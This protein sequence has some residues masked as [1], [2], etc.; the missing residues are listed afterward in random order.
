MNWSANFQQDH[1]MSEFHALQP[2]FYHND[3]DLLHFCNSGSCLSEEPFDK[4]RLETSTT[5][6]SPEHEIPGDISEIPDDVT[7]SFLNTSSRLIDAMLTNFVPNE[8]VNDAIHSNDP[9]PKLKVTSE[10]SYDQATFENFQLIKDCMWSGLGRKP[11]SQVPRLNISSS[12]DSSTFSPGSGCINPRSVFSIAT[13]LQTVKTERKNFPVTHNHIVNPVAGMETPSD[14]EQEI[15]VVTV[16]NTPKSTPNIPTTHGVFFL[17]QK[18]WPERSCERQLELFTTNLIQT[19]SLKKND[20]TLKPRWTSPAEKNIVK[21]EIPANNVAH[22]IKLAA[23]SSLMSIT[24][25]GS[26]KENT[27]PNG[28]KAVTVGA[29][30]RC[31]SLEG[32]SMV[33]NTGIKQNREVIKPELG[34]VKLLEIIQLT[35]GSNSSFIE[36]RKAS[37]KISKSKIASVLA[38]HE[39]PTSSPGILNGDAPSPKK[40]ALSG[41]SSTSS[42]TGEKTNRAVQNFKEKKRRERLRTSVLGLQNSVPHLMHQERATKVV[43]LNMAR[44]HILNL[45]GEAANNQLEKVT[46]QQ[47]QLALQQRCRELL[48][49]M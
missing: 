35:K 41:E 28:A 46:E 30:R 19:Q 21:D 26:K 1:V 49:G 3:E 20:E 8:Y 17:G 45:Q 10:N 23:P 39:T 12:P 4:F 6:R 37:E 16:E 48:H 7:S 42:A 38:A 34:D 43:I 5:L 40:R 44:Q 32:V 2:F 29:K 24:T 14:S 9:L 36:K 31:L 13:A 22:L 18:L 25:S 11:H 47:R 27:T 15:D 33:N